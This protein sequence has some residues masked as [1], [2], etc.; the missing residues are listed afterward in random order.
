MTNEELVELYQAGDENVLEDLLLQNEGFV[1][2]VVKKFYIGWDPAVSQEDLVQEG[3]I[4]L[5]IAAQKFDTGIGKFTTY[6]YPWVFQTMH[7]FLFPRKSVLA[8]LKD[9]SYD[10]SLFE[11]V[12]EDLELQDSLEDDAYMYDTLEDQ[13]DTKQECF[14]VMNIVRSHVGAKG[15]ELLRLRFG[16]VDDIN[17]TTDY[18]GKRL[19]LS[20][21]EYRSLYSKCMRAIKASELWKTK[22]K[23][24]RQEVLEKAYNTG[25]LTDQFFVELF[26]EI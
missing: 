26:K 16:L 24:Y 15:V 7:K 11:K 1:R 25:K 10:R 17:H 14:Q 3:Y 19:G 23:D 20:Y 6:A 2:K 21:E 9:K 13:I 5:M 8:K 12:T 4:G 18:I 22:R